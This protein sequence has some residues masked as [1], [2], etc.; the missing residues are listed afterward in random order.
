MNRESHELK[1]LVT[2]A[3]DAE[4]EQELARALE[5]VADALVQRVLASTSAGQCLLSANTQ[6][7]DEW[8]KG[9]LDN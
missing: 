6:G 1:V 7:R 9:F 2:T 4:A 5:S 3:A 8:T